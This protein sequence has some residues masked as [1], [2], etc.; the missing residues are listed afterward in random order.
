MIATFI[1]GGNA[2]EPLEKASVEETSKP[3]QE[4]ER[5]ECVV[6]KELP[7]QDEREI[8][9][10]T[11]PEIKNQCQP[12]EI[13]DP[14]QSDCSKQDVPSA[15]V[16]PEK[17]KPLQPAKSVPG[18]TLRR[19]EDPSYTPLFTP[20]NFSSVRPITE[21]PQPSNP[22]P[23]RT[24]RY[25]VLEAPAEPVKPQYKILEAVGVPSDVFY[26]P[27]TENPPAPATFT[28]PYKVLEAPG[29]AAAGSP[30]IAAK[31]VTTPL[32]SSPSSSSTQNR[33]LA[34]DV[35]EKARTRFDRFWGKKDGDKN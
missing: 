6:K 3:T 33:S 35:L 1:A 19:L 16:I 15:E 23:I 4:S 20:S 30:T 25:R 34:S 5:T 21:P 26:Q 18:T 12:T 17:T 9:E 24:P 27:V 8:I 32:L 13:K 29:A 11:V 7:T 2:P 10:K 22:A 14:L 28:S 31:G